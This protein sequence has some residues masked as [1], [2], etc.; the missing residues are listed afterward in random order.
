MGLARG[1]REV[2]VR[3]GSK[4][5]AVRRTKGIPSADQSRGGFTLHSWGAS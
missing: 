3:A 5:G 2:D 4:A 1:L